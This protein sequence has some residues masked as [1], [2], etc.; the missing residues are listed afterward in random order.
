MSSGIIYIAI[1]VM[2]AAYLVPLALRRHE[3]HSEKRSVDRFSRAMRV[4]SRRP[5]VID[6]RSVVMPKRPG[7]SRPVV[8]GAAPGSRPRR[9]GL[10]STAVPNRVSYASSERPSTHLA[11][12]RL[13]ARRRQTLLAL[14]GATLVLLIAP[15]LT[16]AVPGWAW[17]LA[18]LVTGGFAVHLRAQSRRELELRRR[19]ASSARR[20]EGRTRRIDS[21]ERVV[22]VRRQR[23]AER[24]AAAEVAAGL[25]WEREQEQARRE[26]EDAAK[27]AGWQPVPVTLPT[28]VTKPKAAPAS[29]VIDLTRPGRWAE[30]TSVSA[31]ALGAEDAAELVPRVGGGPAV[32]YDEP[33]DDRRVPDLDDDPELTGTV[34][35]RRAVND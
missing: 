7:H 16:S 1:L 4:L 13:M 22:E 6:S 34:E 28:Y 30:S 23:E 10:V 31:D 14:G 2:W 25:A 5:P 8:D 21:A 17:V 24:A 11:R 19:R 15:M 35:R 18:L 26:A 33:Y 27:V 12:A 32:A 3:E 29:R 20:R 9:G